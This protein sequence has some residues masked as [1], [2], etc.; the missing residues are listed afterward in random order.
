MLV[1]RIVCVNKNPLHFHNVD[2]VLFYNCLYFISVF[3]STNVTSRRDP[4]TLLPL[5]AV[6][7]DD[8]DVEVNFGSATLS[9]LPCCVGHSCSR[10]LEN[11]NINLCGQVPR[12]PR[13]V[14]IVS[15]GNF[16]PPPLAI[17]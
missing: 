3:F 16:R 10:G 12:K 9:S 4:S 8:D 14:Q 13:L 11:L 15:T 2:L 1:Y 6:D 5:S 17:R 7:N